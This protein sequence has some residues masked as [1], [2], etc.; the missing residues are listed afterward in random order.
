MEAQIN[1]ETHII[2]TEFHKNSKKNALECLNSLDPTWNA[3]LSSGCSPDTIQL[4][5][6]RYNIKKIQNKKPINSTKVLSKKCCFYSH[7]A[8]WNHCVENNLEF[9]VVLEHDTESNID[10]PLRKIKDFLAENAC[11]GIQLTT[12]SML[13][14]LKKYKKYK[15]HYNSLVDGIHEIFYVHAYGK[16]FFA[17]GTGYILDLDACKYLIKKVYEEGWYQ[18]DV[19]FSIEDDFPLYFLKPSPV[20]Y[21]P[22]KEINSS[23]F[24]I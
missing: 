20:E 14:H 24:R 10:F 21:L 16:R 12:E 1:Y 23:S 7:F 3:L 13:T 18:N 17:G 15:G 11:V 9:I 19:M 5:E 8:I 22:R 4:Y 2:Y 6:N